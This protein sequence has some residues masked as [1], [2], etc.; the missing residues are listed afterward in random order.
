MSNTFVFK[1]YIITETDEKIYFNLKQ[2]DI[3]FIYCYKT[4]NDL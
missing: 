2:F 4:G 1:E 3:D